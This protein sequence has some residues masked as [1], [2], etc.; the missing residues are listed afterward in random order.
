MENDTYAN[1]WKYILIIIK[2][3]SEDFCFNGKAFEMNV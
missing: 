3:L 1:I 2:G